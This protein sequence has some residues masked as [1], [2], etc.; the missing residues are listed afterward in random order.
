M[1]DN[2]KTQMVLSWFSVMITTTRFVILLQYLQWPLRADF[3][4]SK[5]VRTKTV[6][7]QSENQMYK[8]LVVTS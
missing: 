4:L 2:N 5:T 7:T 1:A 8:T 6:K 3:Q